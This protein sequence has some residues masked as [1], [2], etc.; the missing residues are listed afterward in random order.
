MLSPLRH[1]VAN[2]LLELWPDLPGECRLQAAALL[3]Y[4]CDDSHAAQ[5]DRRISADGPEELICWAWIAR[6]HLTVPVHDP[7]LVQRVATLTPEVVKASL[8]ALGMTG[9]RQLSDIA[10][11]DVPE[12]VRLRSSWWLRAG[13]AVRV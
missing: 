5:L 12:S 8:Y 1:V 13:A 6:A 3:T 11:A 9:S 7:A 10:V 2:A 4:V